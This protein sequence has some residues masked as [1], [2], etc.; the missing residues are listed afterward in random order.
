MTNDEAI[1]VLRKA[2]NLIL[3]YTDDDGFIY[4]TAKKAL[5]DTKAVHIDPNTFTYQKAK[6]SSVIEDKNN[7]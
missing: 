6:Y 4:Q 3:N 2:L 7:S 5:E 1:A